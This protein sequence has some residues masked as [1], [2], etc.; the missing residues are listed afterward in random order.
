MEISA[1][2][3][4][5][6]KSVSAIP[7]LSNLSVLYLSQLE[8][9]VD[10]SWRLA[11]P[12]EWFSCLRP[13]KAAIMGGAAGHFL[14]FSFPPSFRSVSSCKIL[15]SASKAKPLSNGRAFKCPGVM[16]WCQHPL[17][18]ENL[19]EGLFSMRKVLGSNPSFAKHSQSKTL[20]PPRVSGES[21][22]S[23]PSV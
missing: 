10:Y 3:K 13:L 21:L 11:F 22:G 9:N 23:F 14:C 5:D 18:L 2:L 16:S 7:H 17:P 6:V 8:A 1:S 19:P 4:E 15:L 20:G 12:L